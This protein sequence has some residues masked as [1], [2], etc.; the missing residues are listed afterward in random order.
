MIS[1]CDDV[2]AQ[3]P[4]RQ[5]EGGAI[6][7]LQAIRQGG[8]GGG[9]RGAGARTRTWCALLSIVFSA[10]SHKAVP[11]LCLVTAGQTIAGQNAAR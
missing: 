7:R 1:H 11:F 4:R 6:A 9:R 3:G 10:G 2:L 8:G 5:K